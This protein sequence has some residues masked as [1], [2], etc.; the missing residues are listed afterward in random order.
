MFFCDLLL[1]VSYYSRDALFFSRV[2]LAYNPFYSACFFNRNS[3]FFS[4]KISEQC[5]SVGLYLTLRGEQ[6]NNVSK[7]RKPAS[8]RIALSGVWTLATAINQID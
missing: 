1:Y 6:V 4:Q 8:S 3:I 5:F 2:H 7:I